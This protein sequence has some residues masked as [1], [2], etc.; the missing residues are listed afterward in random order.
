[1]S[2]KDIIIISVI[3]NAGLLVILLI[4]AL[5]TKESY[6]VSSSAQ[7]ASTILE[8]DT[9]GMVPAKTDLATSLDV[10][11]EEPIKVEAQET[12]IKM[13]TPKEEP[14]V[15]QLPATSEM[16]ET[17]KPEFI[18]VVVKKGDTVE[19]IAKVNHTSIN[20][21]V[22]TNELSNTFLRVGQ[23]LRIPVELKS[24][25][26]SQEVAK[27][28]YY[29]VKVGDNPWTI[30]MKHHLKVDELLKMNKLNNKTAKKLRPGDKLRIR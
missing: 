28:D 23:T 25:N 21:I 13:E 15:H 2:R 26:S 22:K 4:S 7:V 14:I 10:K 8:N 12:A 11:K 19:K 9:N 20:Q 27:V 6:L 18:E 24:D 3:V 5:T 17:P 29:T 30:A 16:T 1:M